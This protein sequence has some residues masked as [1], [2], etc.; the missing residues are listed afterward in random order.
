MAED[1]RLREALLELQLLREREAKSLRETRNLLECLEA[2]SRATTPGEA[3]SSIFVSLRNT[4]GA[5][6]S[7]LGEVSGDRT[8]TVSASDNRQLIGLRLEPPYDLAAR[9]R[10]VLDLQLLGAWNG[11]FDMS[12][13]TSLQSVPLSSGGTF[14][15]LVVLKK[16]RHSFEKGSIQLVERLAGLAL[17]ALQGSEIADENKLL[18][19][20]I[21][22]SSSG[23][24][25]ADATK[26]ERPLIYVNEAFER[27]S[28]YT[29]S[30]VLGINCRFLTAEAE[31]S[32]E[33]S[34]LRETVARNG[35]GQFL[36]KNRRKDGTLFWNELTLFPVAGET[37]E[38]RSLVATQ[39][40][41][42][43][44]VEAAAERDRTRAQ[45]A[46]A[47]TATGDAFLV[48]T[49]EQRVA[50]SN[51][52]TRDIFPSG[53]LNW[54]PGTTFRDNWEAYIKASRD[55]P[56][57]ITSLLAR[58][59]LLGLA[60]LPN[61]REIDLPDGRTI[62]IRASDLADGGIV[63]SATDVTPMKS[64]QRLLSQRLAAIEAT[65][66]GIA[67]TDDR[68]RLTY[69]NS[70][71]ATLLGFG[72]STLGL[73]KAW[74]DRYDDG[75]RL[76]G[77]LAFASTLTRRV[78]TGERTHE[79][80]GTI[81]ESGGSV[82]VFRDITERLAYETREADLKAGLQQLQ[83]QEATGQLT[84]GIAHDFNNL[85]SAINGSATLIGLEESLTDSLKAHVDRI[86]TAGTQAARLVNR[87]LDIG[88]S[89]DGGGAFGFG[90]VFADIP[91]LIAPSLPSNI[92]FTVARQDDG[93]ALK[94]DPG[95]LSQVIVNLVLNARDAIG[96]ADGTIAV[97]TS[98]T[99]KRSAPD[100]QAGELLSSQTYLRL[101]VRDTGS[102]IKPEQLE[103]V[104]EPYFSTKGR[105]GTGLG[106]A[107]VSIQ[108]QAIG[109]AVGISSEIG[110][111][112]T[113]S[114]FWPL[115]NTEVGNETNAVP[116]AHDLTGQTIIVVDDD[117]DVAAVAAKYLEA[118]GAEVAVCN[119]P[120][121]A[122]EAIEDDPTAWSAVITDYDMP[123]MTGGD[124]AERV[125]RINQDIPVLLV[126]A[127]ARRLSDPRINDGTIDVVLAKPTDLK[128]LTSVISEYHQR[129]N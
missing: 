2:Y 42:S 13:F 32:E 41:V 89:S 74:Y 49:E 60:Q 56:G 27:I 103:T 43:Q 91:A 35:A 34:R 80:T 58:P 101:D 28:G 126:T 29:A 6:L 11:E 40:D 62:L 81:L 45:M 116:S 112:T 3:L 46:K 48:L 128:H 119:D 68:G 76:R 118:Q 19:A 20:A 75:E 123:D 88:A 63:L 4:I 98:W 109:G 55:M 111:G 37:G 92:A 33:R 115:A 7:L 10:D 85:L 22:G 94:G 65:Q 83:R 127:L 18:A 102:G 15:A 108:V 67:T 121:D 8:F 106:L 100:V 16:A 129:R 72:A 36:I 54:A 24:A 114:V 38:V 69:L 97:E 23:F 66:D 78:G 51:D 124:V 96:D 26:A 17:R 12:E 117:A 110:K 39:N 104:F 53:D 120:R 1:E 95:A 86:S 44:R 30:E 71:A 93:F 61:G 125:K 70:A 21:H 122:V 31:D 79:V 105:R 87:L 59:D 107:M 73:G 5:D 47:L 9:A 99:E 82:I 57:R 52:A 77:H 25:I 90:S 50:F 64:A 14:H 113:V 84:A